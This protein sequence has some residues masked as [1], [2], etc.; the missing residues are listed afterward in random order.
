[1]DVFWGREHEL[2]V[3]PLP[4]GIVSVALLALP[5][6]FRGSPNDILSHAIGLHPQ[7]VDSLA[8]CPQLEPAAGASSWHVTPAFRHA[9]G[10][11]LHGDAA[12]YVDPITGG[13]MTQALLTS[14]LVAAALR[15]GI[16]GSLEALDRDRQA[17]LRGYRL[18]TRAALWLAGR[19]LASMASF[20]LLRSWPGL[21]SQLLS[22]AGSAR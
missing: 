16:P 15:D 5:G 13:G 4:D 7:L 21:F 6:F 17:M 9:P 12:G 20:E 14:R 19:P 18:L 10:F 1:V 8:G 2:Y 22:V 3:T 11:L